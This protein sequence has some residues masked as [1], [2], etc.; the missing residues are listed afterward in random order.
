M[1]LW[2]LCILHFGT[3]RVLV[4]LLTRAPDRER[5]KKKSS[6]GARRRNVIPDRRW[7]SWIPS[8]D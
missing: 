3:C 7:G 4:E 6:G 5:E 1:K 2:I 8:S